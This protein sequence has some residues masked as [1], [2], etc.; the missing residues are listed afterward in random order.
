MYTLDIISS[1]DLYSHSTSLKHISKFPLIKQT[2]F[3]PYTYFL[4]SNTT[5][6]KI[7]LLLAPF[8]SRELAEMCKTAVYL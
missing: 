3:F 7:S 8:F 5:K 4:S 1:N 2:L 6:R